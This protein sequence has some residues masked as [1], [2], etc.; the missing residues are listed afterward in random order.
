MGIFGIGK[1][2]FEH[3]QGFPGEDLMY[4]IFWLLFMW[5]ELDCLEFLNSIWV[6]IL[7][8]RS[9]KVRPCAQPLA[10]D[11]SGEW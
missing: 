9:A 10:R 6:S 1:Y 5:R 7:N 11:G 2:I 8:S 3:L 4:V